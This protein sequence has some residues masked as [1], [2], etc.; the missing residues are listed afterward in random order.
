MNVGDTLDYEG[1]IYQ[2]EESEGC[3]G[4]AFLC[5][6]DMCMVLDEGGTIPCICPTSIFGSCKASSR[7]DG[8]NVIFKEVADEEV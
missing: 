1:T 7:H 8:R 6:L 5:S 2:C 4:C 3:R